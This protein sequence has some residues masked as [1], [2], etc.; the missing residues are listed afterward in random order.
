[1]RLVEKLRRIAAPATAGPP[2]PLGARLPG[3]RVQA[4]LHAVF[5]SFF[6]AFAG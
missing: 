1:M 3:D 6:R 4:A 5:F 2:V